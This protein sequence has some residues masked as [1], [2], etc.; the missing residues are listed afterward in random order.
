MTHRTRAAA[1]MLVLAG[2]ACAGDSAG[3]EAFCDAARAMTQVEP[4]DTE[5]TL[6]TYEQLRAE[7]PDEIK[8]AINTLAD[9][10][11]EAFES[12]DATVAQD[13]EFLAASAEFDA[14]LEDNCEAPE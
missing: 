2:T 8:S 4:G 14:Y 12:Q 9:M 13:P 6:D 1:V 3:A 7:A 5:K 10:T 11:R